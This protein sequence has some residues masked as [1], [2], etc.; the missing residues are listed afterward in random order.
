M[1][2]DKR[3]YLFVGDFCPQARKAIGGEFGEN[4]DFAP[5]LETALQKMQENK[6]QGLVTEAI[7]AESAE[8]KVG[9]RAIEF[10]E[11]WQDRLKK[12]GDNPF[13]WAAKGPNIGFILMGHALTHSLSSVLICPYGN[14]SDPKHWKNARLQLHSEMSLYH[15][16]LGPYLTPG[17]I[18]DEL[19]RVK[20]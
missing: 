3:R 4:L 11:D 10:I 15:N 19:Q 7:I 16:D 9:D 20:S 12:T 14:K 2:R 5:D 8:Y 13:C 17:K 1:L 6:Y 18:I